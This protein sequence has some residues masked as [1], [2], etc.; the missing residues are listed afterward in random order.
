MMVWTE[1]RE[2]VEK[3]NID[4]KEKKNEPAST[5]KKSDRSTNLELNV[6]RE[7]KERIERI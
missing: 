7:E 4:G 6:K 3:K 5:A 2:R 1:K